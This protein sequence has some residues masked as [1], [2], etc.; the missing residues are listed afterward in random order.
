MKGQDIRF[1]V[2]RKVVRIVESITDGVSAGLEIGWDC[3]G[4]EQEPVI[5]RLPMELVV[6][7]PSEDFDEIL[8]EQANS[9]AEDRDHEDGLGEAPC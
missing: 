4:P 3:L 9:T 8:F 7:E 6:D 5:A 1:S 2:D